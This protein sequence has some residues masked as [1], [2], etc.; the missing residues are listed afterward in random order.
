MGF[1]ID[2]WEHLRP[3]GTKQL[4]Q[5]SMA[6]KWQ[7]LDSNPPLPAPTTVPPQAKSRR[8]ERR[9]RWL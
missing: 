1:T 5:V 3:G 4:V 8:R 7:G 2:R 9:Q 6:S